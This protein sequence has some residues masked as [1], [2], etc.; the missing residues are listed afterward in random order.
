MRD[1]LENKL[2]MYRAVE[3]L[4]DGNTAKTAGMTIFATRLA[5]FKD[6][7]AQILEKEELRTNATAGA[8][9]TKKA[10]REEMTEQAAVLAA[11]MKA[12]GSDTND[13]R[14]LEI[15]DYKRTDLNKMRDTQLLPV[16]QGLINTAD[17]YAAALVPYG[18]AAADIAALGTKMTEYNAAFGSKESAFDVKG[19]AYPAL[20]NLFKQAD[21][22][23]EDKL[24]N[25]ME[26][27]KTTDNEF[28]N[29]YQLA[30]EIIDLGVRHEEEEPAPPEPPQ[31]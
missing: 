8:T 24:D 13:D 28:Y 12:L 23:L 11:K 10:K 29:Q 20:L 31:P 30:R 9:S 5:E 19:A 26:G 3:S 21:V 18:V 17:A 1:P 14:L 2:T 27:F 4:L 7:I 22:L 15:A 16:I 25:L 6:I